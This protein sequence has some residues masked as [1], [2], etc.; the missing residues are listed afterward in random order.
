MCQSS[1]TASPPNKHH[2]WSE[3]INRWMLV[4][5][6]NACLEY[7]I[8]IATYFMVM[9]FVIITFDWNKCN[10]TRCN[11]SYIIDKLSHWNLDVWLGVQP[12]SKIHYIISM[13]TFVHLAYIFETTNQYRFISSLNF[14]FLFIK[15]FSFL[16][17]SAHWPAMIPLVNGIEM[18]TSQRIIHNQI[19]IK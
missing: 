15:D 18:S 17:I 3:K 8:N 5:L 1:A 4:E 12:P 7:S 9:H 19:Y 13:M 16:G 6:V 10:G 14:L 11:N 2:I